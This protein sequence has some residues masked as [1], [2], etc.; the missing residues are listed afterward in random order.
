M[1]WTTGGGHLWDRLKEYDRN[2][3]TAPYYVG[4]DLRKYT[5]TSGAI[6]LNAG[7]HSHA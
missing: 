3:K 2:W 7:G 6:T 1:E 5:L 4:D